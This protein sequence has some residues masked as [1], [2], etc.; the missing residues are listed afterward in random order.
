MDSPGFVYFFGAVGYGHTGYFKVG[1][2]RNNYKVRLKQIEQ[3]SPFLIVPI[4]VAGHSNPESLEQGI[5]LNFKENRI[6]GEWF[7]AFHL[8]SRYGIKIAA[9]FERQVVDFIKK[10][11]DGGVIV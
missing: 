1:V 8:D 7:F 2:T 9:D 3:N 5:L 6:K 10:N 4:C 11:S